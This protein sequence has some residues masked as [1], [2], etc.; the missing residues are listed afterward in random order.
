MFF[1]TEKIKIFVVIF[2]IIACFFVLL[3]FPEQIEEDRTSNGS[4]FKQR[5]PR[6]PRP[7]L[8][9][10]LSSVP[11]PLFPDLFQVSLCCSLRFTAFVP[12]RWMVIGSS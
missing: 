7:P 10:P 11:P 12:P 8:S 2:L 1:C 9:N 3:L 4:V 5:I 6:D